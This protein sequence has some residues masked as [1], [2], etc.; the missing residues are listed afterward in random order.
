MGDDA[1]EEV[2]EID[3]TQVSQAGGGGGGGGGAAEE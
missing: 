1:F 3:S 2:L